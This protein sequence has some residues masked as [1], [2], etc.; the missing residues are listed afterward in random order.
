MLSAVER[1][2]ADSLMGRALSGLSM[3]YV[4]EQISCMSFVLSGRRYSR[5]RYLPIR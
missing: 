5:W 1:L 3:K 2:V 4:F